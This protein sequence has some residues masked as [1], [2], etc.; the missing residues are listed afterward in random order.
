VLTDDA[1]WRRL[2]TEAVSRPLPVWA[3]T[4]QA[5]LAGLD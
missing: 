4:A 5:L 2:T 3:D 1:E